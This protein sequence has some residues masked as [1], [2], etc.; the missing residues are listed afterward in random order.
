MQ[1]PEGVGGDHALSPSELQ[2]HP[3]APAPAPA[4]AT[5]LRFK[6][7]TTFGFSAGPK[8]DN[9]YE[10]VSTIM[11]PANSVYAVGSTPLPLHHTHTAQSPFPMGRFAPHIMFLPYATGKSMTP[12]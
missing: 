3:L 4:R 6:C 5:P 2:V 12:T 11:G 8:G 9:L 7:P 10:W 1:Y